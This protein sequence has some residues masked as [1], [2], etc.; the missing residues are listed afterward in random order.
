M[1]KTCILHFQDGKLALLA[2]NDCFMSA[3]ISDDSIVA[4]NKKAGESEFLK[5]RTSLIT[6]KDPDAD[7]P[8]EERGNLTQVEEN[9]VRKFQKFQDKKLKICK[10]DKNALKK[11]KDDGNFHEALLDRRSKMKADRYCK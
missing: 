10:E 11:A 8:V 4:K 5:I 6:E 1:L 2:S 3:D 9:F 7:V